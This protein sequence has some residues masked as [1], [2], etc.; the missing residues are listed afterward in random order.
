MGGSEPKDFSEYPDSSTE[1]NYPEF[2][3]RID[4]HAAKIVFDRFKCPIVVFTFDTCLRS[5]HMPTVDLEKEFD[6]YRSKS[7]RCD[8]LA[9]I[10][11]KH[12][13]KVLNPHIFRSCDLLAT[14]GTF[15]ADECKC[16]RKHLGKYTIEVHDK[17]LNGIFTPVD[18]AS[19]TREIELCISLSLD[20]TVRV[21][22]EHLGKLAKLDE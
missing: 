17:K 18:D 13:A 14:I 7:Q 6:K 4:P 2:N 20:D 3:F 8:F 1:I 9:N 22:K 15:Y 10:G 21:F 12:R 5:F 16:V 19:E 11:L